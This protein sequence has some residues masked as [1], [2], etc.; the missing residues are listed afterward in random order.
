MRAGLVGCIEPVAAT[1]FSALWLGTPVT[2]ADLAG[3]A[4]ILAMVVL[5]TVK[6]KEKEGM[7]R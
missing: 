3:M 1:A 2:W 4:L 5:V 7:G 6:P